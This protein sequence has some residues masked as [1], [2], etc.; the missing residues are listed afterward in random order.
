VGLS[1]EQ[2]SVG[3]SGWE[4]TVQETYDRV[5]DEY[6]ER[7]FGE[8]AGKPF[9]REVLDRFAALALPLGPVCDLGCGPG[10]V[11]RYLHEGWHERGLEAFGI[12]LAPGMVERARS[13]N[14]GLRFEQGTMLALDLADDSLGG[15][16]AFYSIVN[17][18]AADQPRAFAELH[19]VLKPG[20]WLLVAFHVGDETVHLDD[21]W[22][23]PVSVDFYFFRPDDVAARLEAAG[24]TIVERHVREPYPEVEHPSRRAYLLARKPADVRS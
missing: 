23:I 17:V 12:D 19:R 5:A 8:L 2:R 3:V 7:I 24:L 4:R 13:L 1:L 6:A 21:W 10:Q 22:E 18:P 16:V 15:I 14:P 20:G 9:D 11:A